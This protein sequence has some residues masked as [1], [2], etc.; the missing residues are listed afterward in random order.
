MPNENTK[1][2]VVL[3]DLDGT[4]AQDD[5]TYVEGKVGWPV[6]K[7]VDFCKYQIGMGMEVRIFTARADNP[8]DVAAIREWL[9]TEAELP[10]KRSEFDRLTA[11]GY[12]P[13]QLAITNVK[14]RDAVIIIDDK[15]YH[16]NKNTGVID[17]LGTQ[18]HTK[19]HFK[20][21]NRKPFSIQR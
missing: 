21:V 13:E 6:R 9:I 18:E 7:I 10:C 2:P 19:P 11:E 14:G 20:L 3:C 8:V 1:K 5:G 15:A 12:P 17:G 16:C 4:L